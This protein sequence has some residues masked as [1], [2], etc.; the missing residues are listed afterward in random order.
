MTIFDCRLPIGNFQSQIEN[1]KSAMC[2]WRSLF[3]IGY[4]RRSWLFRQDRADQTGSAEALSSLVPRARGAPLVYT[5][6]EG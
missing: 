5:M 4:S 1:R 2:Y 3:D 6:E